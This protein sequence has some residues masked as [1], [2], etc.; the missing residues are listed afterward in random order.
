LTTRGLR[1][2]V[3]PVAAKS[4]TG[5]DSL[6]WSG[7]EP[8]TFRLAALF[9]S[10][11]AYG[12]A[13]RE[14]R[15]ALPVLHRSVNPFGPSTSFDSGADGSSSELEHTMNALACAPALVVASTHVRQ[16]DGLY[17]LNDLHRAAGAQP[18]HQP[19][20]FMRLYQT[21]A[22][23]E[24]IANSTDVQ[25][26]RAK[27]GRNG[28]TYVCRELVIAYGMWISAKFH[29]AVIRAFDALQAAPPAAPSGP[30]AALTGQRFL[31]QFDAA[32]TPTFQALASDERLLTPQMITWLV[33]TSDFPL[34]QLYP[35]ITMAA[36]RLAKSAGATPD[37][38]DV[39][40]TFA[41]GINPNAGRRIRGEPLESVG[42]QLAR[43]A[44]ERN[45]A[46]R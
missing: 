25:S 35:L 13:G 17:S 18:K 42:Q 7:D 38:S 20:L 19:A 5:I 6:I 4:A 39:F 45:E 36:H 44:K 21:R 1:S 31:M 33:G 22:L 29:L 28:G 15:E 3:Y 27:G 9:A 23:I 26:F 14:G 46:H 32:G 12:R 37:V 41:Q 11:S 8:Q 43:E 30:A 10:G 34:E 24:E 16:M 2:T 40:G